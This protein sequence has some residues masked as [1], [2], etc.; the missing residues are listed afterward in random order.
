MSFTAINS[1]AGMANGGPSRD[2]SKE[3]EDSDKMTVKAQIKELSAEKDKDAL[4]KEA[5]IASLTG[6]YDI[7]DSEL[8]L[9][10]KKSTSYLLLRHMVIRKYTKEFEPEEKGKQFQTFCCHCDKFWGPYDMHNTTT[11]YL[12]RHFSIEHPELPKSYLEEEAVLRR[13]KKENAELAAN[14]KDAND[15]KGKGKKKGGKAKTDDLEEVKAGEQGAEAEGREQ[16]VKSRQASA[17]KPER[18]KRGRAIAEPETPV[19]LKEVNTINAITTRSKG[20]EALATLRKTRSGKRT[21]EVEN[22]TAAGIGLASLEPPTTRKRR[23]TETSAATSRK[24]PAPSV[25][26]FL[27]E[28]DRTL[29]NLLPLEKESI[30]P[31][32]P[33]PTVEQSAT[34]GTAATLPTPSSSSIPMVPPTADP[35][36]PQTPFNESFKKLLTE[37]LASSETSLSVIEMKEFHDLIGFLNPNAPRFNFNNLYDEVFDRQEEIR[38]TKREKP[39]GSV[40]TKKY[41]DSLKKEKERRRKK[42]EGYRAWLFRD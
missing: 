7:L 34:A 10:L 22:V 14:S 3:I 17:G 6:K 15:V 18:S 1:V 31:P 8:T 12:M 2:E 29:S 23:R 16:V 25:E 36:I 19:Q 41:E 40:R 21:G 5:Y 39:D 4:D 35:S 11:S 20:D 33:P 28:A 26:G 24:N 32:L 37:F 42:E 27:A 30:D 13:M 38:T 9:S